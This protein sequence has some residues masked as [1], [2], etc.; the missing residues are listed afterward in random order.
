MKT[1]FIKQKHTMTHLFRRDFLKLG[2][3]VTGA[4]L[5]PFSVQAAFDSKPKKVKALAFYNTHTDEKLHVVFFRDGKYDTGALT[6]INYILRD[7]R[8]AEIK[9]IDVQLLELLHAISNKTRSQAPFHVISGYRSPTTNKSLRKKSKGVAS[10]S[11]HMLGKA[12]DFRIPG[13]STRQ[14]RN[15][16]RKMKGG[17]VGYYPKSDFLHVDIGRVR[18]W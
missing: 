13:F 10:K 6:K 9:A 1:I 16:A 12:I 15:V 11:M 17:G 14:L 7:H 3:M 5:N 4:V 18:Y 8:S 2:F